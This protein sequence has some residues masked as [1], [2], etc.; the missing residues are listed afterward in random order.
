M[1]I[2]MTLTQHP[3]PAVT[4]TRLSPLALVVLLSGTFLAMTDFFVVNVA[5]PVIGHDLS[6]STSALELVIAGY[7]VAY[8]LGLVTGGRLGDAYGRKRLFLLGMAAFT[9]TSALCG[10]APSASALVG[11]RIAQGAAAALMVPQ[12]LATIQ[13]ATSG[14][15]RARALAAFGATG[16]LAAVFGQLGGGLIVAADILGTSWRPIFL[17]NVPIGIVAIAVAARVLPDSRADRAARVD[18]PGTVLLGAAVLAL[19]VPLVEGRSQG[20]PAWTWASLAAAPV[21]AWA[22]LRVEN[23][24]ERT[25][26][27]P[28]LPPSLLR[29]PGMRRGLAIGVPFFTGF[30]GFMFVYAEFTQVALHW[31][32]LKAGA[33]LTPMGLTFLAV[34]LSTARLLARWGRRSVISVGAA[35]Q[36]SGLLLLA[37]TVLRAGA[38]ASPLELAPGLILAGAGQAMV[39]PTLIGV[40]LAEVPPLLAGAGSGIFFTL[41]QSSLALG[42]AV[43]GSVFLEVLPGH[44]PGTAYA[45]AVGVQL[46]AA[47]A[48]LTV[49]RTLPARTPEVQV[50]ERAEPAAALQVAARAISPAVEAMEM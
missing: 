38:G 17:L 30:G 1:V 34:S 50:S 29:L 2:T 37:V 32:A 44:G 9:L 42:V 39:M 43:F 10:F 8:A 3:A 35:L 5:L 15:E 26:H 48:V 41:Q 7:A 6:A 25:G 24:V 49:A 22:L 14:Q 13:A 36:G 23:R 45:A 4:T 33:A 28:L 46:L 19:L 16:G 31:S 47:V 11:A 27:T 20:W 12:V 40:I 21:L 18:V